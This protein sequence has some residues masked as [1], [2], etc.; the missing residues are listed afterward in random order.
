[1]AG[2]IVVLTVTE[3]SH[4]WISVTH[5]HLVLL[6]PLPPPLLEVLKLPALNLS[7]AQSHIMTFLIQSVNT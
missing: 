5:R 3:Q 1:M 2:G 7:M 4:C 6:P